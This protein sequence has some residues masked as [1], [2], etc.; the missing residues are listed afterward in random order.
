MVVLP[1]LGAWFGTTAWL[2]SGEIGSKND[3]LIPG[4]RTT[5][6]RFICRFYERLDTSLGLFGEAM[7]TLYLSA[8]GKPF[9]ARRRT[10][11]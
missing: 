9:T 10:I 11:K 2:V 6:F 3:L 4:Q 8:I 7:D 5:S 1:D